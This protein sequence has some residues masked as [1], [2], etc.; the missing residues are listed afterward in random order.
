MPALDGVGVNFTE[1]LGLVRRFRPPRTGSVRGVRAGLRQR[2]TEVSA[3]GAD[4]SRLTARECGQRADEWRALL[5]D[6]AVN[7]DSD[8]LSCGRW[9][10]GITES[11][12]H[13]PKSNVRDWHEAMWRQERMMAL[14]LLEKEVFGDAGA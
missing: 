3:L 10:F 9:V 8:H 5:D 11:M 7:W 6:P 1:L 13:L 14:L 2:L 4:S 12:G